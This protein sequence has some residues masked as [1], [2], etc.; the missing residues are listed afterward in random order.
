MTASAHNVPEVAQT[1]ITPGQLVGHRQ[2]D[3][4]DACRHRDPLLDQQVHERLRIEGAAEEHL[5]GPDHGRRIGHT[6]RAGVEHGHL[7]QHAVARPDGHARSGRH[8]QRVEEGRP[9]R[10]DDALRSAGR[11]R[12]VAKS[13]GCR[14]GD[15]ETVIG[16]GLSTEEVLIGEEAREVRVGNGVVQDDDRRQITH[17]VAHLRQQ[18]EEVGIDQDGLVVSVLQNEGQLLGRQPDIERVQD[19]ARARNSEVRLKMPGAVPGQC[20]HGSRPIQLQVVE[21]MHE[22]LGAKTH[23]GVGG[24]FERAVGATRDDLGIGAAG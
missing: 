5:L 8:G 1:R 11:S 10:G 23:L 17:D 7:R 13:H 12:R 2:P 4:G 24:P 21:P 18:G 15:V 20:P 9:V 6:P 22:P 19:T 3:G 16:V 14:L